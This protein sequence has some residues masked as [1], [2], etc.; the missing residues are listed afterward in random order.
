MELIYNSPYGQLE[1]GKE[2][3][4]A[5]AYSNRVQD[6]G[7]CLFGPRA[8]KRTKEI[9]SALDALARVAFENDLGTDIKKLLK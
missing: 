4:E 3:F 8:S 5:L 9:E 1:I 2:L 7:A 6:S